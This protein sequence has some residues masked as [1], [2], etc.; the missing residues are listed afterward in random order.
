MPDAPP[1]AEGHVVHLLQHWGDGAA[2]PSL[3]LRPRLGPGVRI[4]LALLLTAGAA[5]AVSLVV[6]L[7]TFPTPGWWFSLLFTVMVGG[8]AL[9]SWAG[10][11]AGLRTGQERERASA[12]WLERSARARASSGVVVS[13]ETATSESGTVMR[14]QLTA[15][16]EGG[17][18]VRGTW[19]PQPGASSLLQPQVPGVGS[20]VR[21]WGIEPRSDADP[22]V[23][24]VLDP[25]VTSPSDGPDISKYVD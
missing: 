14:F 23:I 25:T 3:R 13:R 19:R 6:V 24:E 16:T 21:V 2:P 15:T 8:L 1:P 20:P 17:A 5:I 11:I 12:A 10:F 4:A 9:G 7:W 22:V 18:T